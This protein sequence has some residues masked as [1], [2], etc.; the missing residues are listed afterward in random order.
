[1]RPSEKH[2]PDPE[3]IALE[4]AQRRAE[5]ALIQ[6]KVERSRLWTRVLRAGVSVGGISGVVFVLVTVAPQQPDSCWTTGVDA[7]Q[8]PKTSPRTH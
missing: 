8:L 2:P 7:P 3:L 4:R 5:V 6:Q 1:M